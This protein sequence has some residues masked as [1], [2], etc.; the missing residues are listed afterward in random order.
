MAKF[1]YVLLFVS[2][3]FVLNRKLLPVEHA[4]GHSVIKYQSLFH[5]ARSASQNKEVKGNKLL[6]HAFNAHIS[7]KNPRVKY[8]ILR[9]NLKNFLKT[10]LQIIN[11]SIDRMGDISFAVHTNVRDLTKKNKKWLISLFGKRKTAENCKSR[12]IC[13]RRQ[14]KI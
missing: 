3:S 10:S 12:K 11:L 9:E 7:D 13:R 4:R 14:N 8:K 6:S 5:K 2:A 1:G